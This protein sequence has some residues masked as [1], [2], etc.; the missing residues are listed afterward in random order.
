MSAP[1]VVTRFAPSPSGEL[2]LGNARTALFNYLLARRH[3]GQFVLRIEDTDAARSS[4]THVTA[5]VADL[6]WLGL[7]WDT[8]PG[9]GM[10]EHAWRQSARGDVYEPC[11]QR[12]LAS[13]AAYPCYCTALELEVSRRAQLAAG[14]PPRYAGTC[15]GLDAAARAER[16]ARGL[17]PALR[18]AVPPEQA[19]EFD[20]LVHGP[21]RLASDDIGDF[22]IRREDGGSAFFFCNAVDDADMGVTQLLRGEDHL[23]NTPRQLL[24]LSALGMRAPRYGHVSL[25]TGGDGAP[26]SKRHGA[27][28]LRELREQG[29]GAM[30]INNLLFRLGHSTPHLGLLTL[31]QMSAGFDI[32]HLQR[33]SAH[34]D[35][36]QLRH[37][38]REWLHSLDAAQSR[39]WLLQW[40]P[41][42]D[43]VLDDFLEAI[44][45]NVLLAADVREWYAILRTG[46][47][48]MDEDAAEAIRT[49]GPDFFAAAAAVPVESG[50]D[51]AA[52]RAATGVKGA[53]FFRP[54]RAALTGRLHGPEIAPLL[55]ALGGQSVQMRLAA[56]AAVLTGER[57]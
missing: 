38:Q 40:L 2:H 5:L 57:A 51:P 9:S 20:D 15:R 21:Q 24:L 25:L 47:F 34:F 27:T 52:L 11:Y 53:A 55:R 13:G 35:P 22:I 37:W 39:V 14:R 8:G 30:A 43:G 3:G 49:A 17:R 56:Q 4:D 54:L 16:V 41:P 31:P 33:A 19:I 7:E 12:L 26:L 48:A 42:A 23:S 50:T 45:P 10:P 18:F 32:A 29:F 44:R 1:S 36:A 46:H 6:H 28:T